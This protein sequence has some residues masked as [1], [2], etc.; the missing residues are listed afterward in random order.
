MAA[1]DSSNKTSK[2]DG[3]IHIRATPE[4]KEAWEA[5]ASRDGRTLSNWLRRAGNY[6]L[7]HPEV[8]VAAPV[9]PQTDTKKPNRT[10]RAG[11]TGPRSRKR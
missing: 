10:R 4:E 11:R 8:P 1:D 5:A 6:R 3:N 9:S 2:K 7:L